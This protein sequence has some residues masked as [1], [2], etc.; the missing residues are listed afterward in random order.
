MHQGRTLTADIGFPYLQRVGPLWSMK[1]PQVF[2]YHHH[3]R[4]YWCLLLIFYFLLQF[5]MADFPAL[6]VPCHCLAATVCQGE[7]A[8]SYVVDKCAPMLWLIFEASEWCYVSSKSLHKAA[9]NVCSLLWSSMIRY[10]ALHHLITMQASCNCIYTL[11]V[12]ARHVE[13]IA[14]IR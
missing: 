13:C 10:G 5:G 14:E 6:V 7:R 3:S 12:S 9:E 1:A 11:H 8:D 2:S 4:Q